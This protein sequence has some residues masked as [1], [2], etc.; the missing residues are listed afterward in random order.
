M[1]EANEVF[2]STDDHT[3]RFEQLFLQ[4]QPMILNLKHD[5]FLR[6]LDHEDWLQESRIAL[7]K[8]IETFDPQRQT[9]F[10]A[11]YR[12]VL[13]N[14][15]CSLLRKQ[16][17][18]KRKPQGPPL[19]LDEGYHEEIAQMLTE[20]SSYDRQMVICET[21]ADAQPFMSKFEARIFCG[22]VVDGKEIPELAEE[23][24]MRPIAVR[25]SLDRARKKLKRCLEMD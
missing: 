9:T 17:A 14:H 3:E 5:Y 25:S 11:Y 19:Y 4:Y 18:L 13:K 20:D 22:Y 1:D 21:L 10:G 2:Y 8:A 12:R 24:E 23:L 15:F 6:D 16:E 7:H